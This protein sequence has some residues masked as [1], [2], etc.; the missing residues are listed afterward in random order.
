MITT[1]KIKKRC[2]HTVTQVFIG[3]GFQLP[4]WERLEEHKECNQCKPLSSREAFLMIGVGCL[5]VTVLYLF[6]MC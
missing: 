1:V 4:V 5:T 2:G 6:G 3:S